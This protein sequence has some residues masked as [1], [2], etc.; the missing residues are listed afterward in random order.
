MNLNIANDIFNNLKENKFVQ[1]FIKELSNYLENNLNKNSNLSNNN[2]LW[3]NLNSEDLTIDNTKI[4]TK[5][6]N[7]ILTERNNILQN[8]AKDT[9]ENGEMYYIYGMSANKNNSYNLCICEE[10]KSHEVITKAMEELP[11]GTT[12]GSVLRKQDND[13]IIDTEATKTIEKQI[14]NMIQEKIEEQKEYLDSRR[15]DGHIYEVGEKY[16]G[17]IWLYDS[18]N[19]IGGGIEGIEEIEFP[20]DL[21]KNAKMGDLFIYQNGDYEKYIQ[22]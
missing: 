9:I 22:Q 18:N 4:I 1:N 7:E 12:L 21:Y 19:S 20:D 11:K 3:N 15:I 16:S 17:R 13:F 14:D 6:K 10:G 2:C 8:Y 5:I